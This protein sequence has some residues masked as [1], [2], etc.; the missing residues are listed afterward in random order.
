MCEG[1][2]TRLSPEGSMP[3]G[4]LSFMG[5]SLCLTSV[6]ALVLWNGHGRRGGGGWGDSGEKAA[7]WPRAPGAFPGLSGP[8][9]LKVRGG[10]TECGVTATRGSH[11][12]FLNW[13]MAPA[14]L[15]TWALGDQMGSFPTIYYS[16]N[17]CIVA[18]PT[19]GT[20]AQQSPCPSCPCRRRPRLPR[21]AGVPSA[22]AVR[23]L[24]GPGLAGESR[25][26]SFPKRP[27]PPG[28]RKCVPGEVDPQ[29]TLTVFICLCVFQVL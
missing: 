14:E 3:P 19:L 9:R 2:P 12:K 23:E 24:P 17:V 22:R 5:A 27:S 28:A 1:H 11:R 25:L 10:W 21:P 26:S 8:H 18:S 29:R 7:G 13:V 16:T 4:A 15:Q 6:G 20:A